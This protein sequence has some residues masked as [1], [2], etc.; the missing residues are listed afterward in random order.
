M[1]EDKPVNEITGYRL[2]EPEYSLSNDIETVF[3]VLP[4][5]DNG[6][7]VAGVSK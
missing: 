1:T 6:N 2:D 7:K 5:D 4:V 3:K